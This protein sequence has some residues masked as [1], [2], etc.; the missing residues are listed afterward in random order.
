[1]SSQVVPDLPAWLAPM[2]EVGRTAPPW[3]S[4]FT[5]PTDGSS[6]AASVLI[7]FGEGAD[8][9]EVLLTERSHDL[10]SHAGQIAFPGGAQDPTDADE[11]ACALREAEEETG[12]DPSGVAVFG[13]LPAFWLPPSNFAVT[14]V[15]G[16]WQTPTAVRAVDPAETASVHLVPIAALLDPANRVTFDHPSGY[17]AAGFQTHGLTVWGFTA[18]LLDRLFELAGWTEPWDRSRI[19]ELPS[20]MVQRSTAAADDDRWSE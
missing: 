10:R 14:P 2:V 5:P 11:I 18:T 19:L 17:R 3:L 9:P 13:E 8:G 6:R 15:L 7:L 20:V 12:L 16:W 4:T 1:M